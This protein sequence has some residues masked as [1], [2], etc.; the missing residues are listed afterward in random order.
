MAF[1]STSFSIKTAIWMIVLIAITWTLVATLLVYTGHKEGFA[2]NTD[3]VENP[4][5]PQQF[6]Y[7]LLTSVMK[8]IR[9]LSSKLT[10]VGMWKE[11][12]DM[13]K[14]TPAELA[15]RHL[16]MERSSR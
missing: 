9:R 16:M 11:R 2:A 7:G 15:R 4:L 12:F 5:T 13:A 10:D 1:T 8:P 6:S 3:D 14:M